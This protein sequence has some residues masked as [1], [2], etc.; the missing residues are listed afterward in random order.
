MRVRA[1]NQPVVVPTVVNL[2]A[3]VAIAALVVMETIKL[4]DG[5]PVA[6]EV[7]L[8]IEGQTGQ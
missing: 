5:Q 3:N 2:D 6:H 4:V 7:S 8:E 1:L